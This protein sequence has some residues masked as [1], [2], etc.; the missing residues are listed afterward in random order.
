MDLG[1]I[2]RVWRRNW[3]AAIGALSSG[4]RVA[5]L[6][7]PGTRGLRVLFMRA[8]GI[9]D[10]ILAT[11]VL[12]AIAESRD[13]LALDVLTTSAAAPVLDGNPHVRHVHLLQR[14]SRRY[15]E[16]ARTVRRARYD[17]IVDGKIT[18]GASFVRSPLLAMIA[19]ASYRVG[20]GGGNHALVYNVCVP[21]FDRTSTHMVEG[22]ALLAI[23]FG[24]RT[25]AASPR[26]EL[27]LSGEERRWAENAW[28]RAASER[29]THGRRWLVNLSVGKAPRRWPTDRWIALLRH[30]RAQRPHDTIAVIGV[31][32]EWSDVQ[33]AA[34][35]GA[36]C[37]V[38]AP[39]LRDAFALVGTSERVLTSDTSITHAASAFRIPIVVML[40]RGLD[41]WA[42]W[43]TPCEIA[44]WTGSTVSAL[45]VDDA[46]GALDRFLLAHPEPSADTHHPA[47]SLASSA[48]Y[49]LSR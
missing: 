22:S 39:R 1:A 2:E 27:F 6:P 8:Q 9:G 10:L 24:A 44:Y 25:A 48:S 45:S 12:R 36:A 43:N 18:R 16:L 34:H 37:P 47:L 33:R 35:E 41:Q 32:S 17:V 20:V 14:T 31:A 3:M 13:A 29:G 46:V 5:T 11:G 38:P 7:A 19:R 40:E 4:E 49:P 30:L 42:P 15:L 28:R 23:P 26:P 21:R